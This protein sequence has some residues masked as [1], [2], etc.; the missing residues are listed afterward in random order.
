MRLPDFDPV[1]WILIGLMGL[2]LAVLLAGICALALPPARSKV[3]DLD[4]FKCTD[5]R[6]ETS[7]TMILSGKTLVPMTTTN[8]V[9]YQWTAK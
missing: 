1:E 8:S 5:S 9:C 2:C 6:E 7:T 3:I 4:V